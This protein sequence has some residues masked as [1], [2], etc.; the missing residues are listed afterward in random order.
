L[1]NAGAEAVADK[2]VATRSVTTIFLICP[3]FIVEKPAVIAD[4]IVEKTFL[5]LIS[6]L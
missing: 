1:A 6:S 4:K 2:R 5:I 3:P